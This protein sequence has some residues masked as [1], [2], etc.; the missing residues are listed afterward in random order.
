MKTI[1]PSKPHGKMPIIALLFFLTATLGAQDETAD[2][3]QSY[4]TLQAEVEALRSELAELRK[5]VHATPSRTTAPQPTIAD[6]Q[7]EIE[8]LKQQVSSAAEWKTSDFFVHLA[9]YFDAGYTNRQSE[10]GTFTLGHFSPIFH[11]Q[12]KDLMLFE[13][14]LTFALEQAP[15]GGLEVE[16][17]IEYLT[18]DLF[19]NDYMV[20]VMGKFLS[21]IG[22][23][24]QNLHPSW[25]N[26]LPSEPIGFSADG[27]HGGSGAAPVADIGAQLRGGLPLGE[28]SAN[29]SF[30]VTNGPR[31]IVEEEHGEW[32]I[33]GIDASGTIDDV[34]ND[35]AIGGRMGFIPFPGLEIGFSAATAEAGLAS[36]TNGHSEEEGGHEEGEHEEDGEETEGFLIIDRDYTVWGADFFYRPRQLKNLVLRGEYLKTEL[37]SGSFDE[38]DPEKKEWEAFYLQGSY[39]LENLRLEPVFRY[40]EFKDSHGVTR[41]QAAPGINY[42]FA[43]NVILKLAYEFNDSNGDDAADELDRFMLQLAFGF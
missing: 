34:N 10:D 32:V 37:G 42:L 12:Y 3:Q 40:G 29:Y 11:Y 21:P 22:Q 25:I 43:N 27:H 15:D 16:A 19:L 20:L 28:R 14:E 26:K 31:L 9:G 8:T 4:N 17:G 39:Y 1:S 24:R 2:L 38:N 23:F 13:G 18:L 5:L 35:K 36:A 6:V 41:T 7:E 33:E 30:F